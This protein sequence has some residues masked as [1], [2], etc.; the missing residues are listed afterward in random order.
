MGREACDQV[1][2]GCLGQG[3]QA[4]HVAPDQDARDLRGD[5][6]RAQLGVG[7]VEHRRDLAQ[8]LPREEAGEERRRELVAQSGAQKHDAALAGLGDLPRLEQVPHDP[9]AHLIARA[10][11]D[12]RQ[13]EIGTHRRTDR[14]AEQVGLG[15]EVVV[16]QRGIHPRPGGD[17]AHRGSVVAALAELVDGRGDDAITR[18]GGPAAGTAPWAPGRRNGVVR[19]PPSLNLAPDAAPGPGAGS[20]C[21]DEA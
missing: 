5:E 12:L 2:D 14:L 9:F 17:R 8:Q 18:V 1:V 13:H 3:R 6:G 19:H 11:E 4:Q 15:A 20:A 21:D 16:Q 10:V 7:G